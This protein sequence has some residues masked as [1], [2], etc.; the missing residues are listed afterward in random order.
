MLL[1]LL[2]LPV[3]LPAA[4]IRYCLEKVA[5]VAEQQ[6]YDDSVVKEELIR[7]QMLLEEGEIDEAEHRARE[8]PLLVR[9]REIKQRRRQQMEEELAESGGIV[10]T[11]AGAVVEVPEEL[12]E[13]R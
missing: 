5:E 11:S 2:G 3:T 1:K 6:M 7:L 9:L 12:E 10:S 13:R 8:A 4:G